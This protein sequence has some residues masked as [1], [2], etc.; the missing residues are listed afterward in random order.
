MHTK[1]TVSVYLR[2]VVDPSPLF[3]ISLAHTFPHSPQHTYPHT[4]KTSIHMRAHTYYHCMADTYPHTPKTS[5]HM[6]AHTYYHCMA[7]TYPHTPKTSIHMRAHT[8][9]HC[10]ADATLVTTTA[11]VAKKRGGKRE[12]NHCIEE[13]GQPLYFWEYTQ[14]MPS[15]SVLNSCGY[16]TPWPKGTHL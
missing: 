16:L 8:Y 11:E 5:I 13:G 7:D 3:P 1:A 9:Y 10:M 15:C 4:P 12:D 14:R 6:R 2:P